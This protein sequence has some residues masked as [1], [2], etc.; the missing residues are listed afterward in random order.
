MPQI[1]E[2]QQRTDILPQ[3]PPGL[4]VNPNAFGAQYEATHRLAGVSADFAE[5]LIQKRAHAAAVDYAFSAAAQDQVDLQK[6]IQETQLNLPKN[7]DGS[8]NYDGY[9]DSINQWVQDRFSQNQKQAPTQLAKQ[10]YQEQAHGMLNRSIVDATGTEFRM[11]AENYKNTILTDL[12]RNGDSLVSVP[13]EGMAKDIW[14]M[15]DRRIDASV[16]TI[17]TPDEAKALKDHSHNVIARS[18]IDGLYA[19]GL[20]EPDTNKS[21]AW[22]QQGLDI[23]N[24]KTSTN[25]GMTINTSAD[26]ASGLKPHEKAQYIDRFERMMNQV[27]SVST[28]EL[29]KRLADSRNQAMNGQPF[30]TQVYRDLDQAVKGGQITPEDRVRLYDSQNAAF[31]TSEIAKEFYT[32]SPDQWKEITS[33]WDSRMAGVVSDFVSR[34]PS[35]KAAQELG[36]NS[37]ERDRARSMLDPIKIQ[38][39][40]DRSDD[41]A[42]Y[43]AKN[44]PG[45][46][47]KQKLAAGDPSAR[48]DYTTSLLAA[49]DSLKIPAQ[50]QRITTKS[51][52]AKLGSYLNTSNPEQAANA[53][54]YLQQQYGPYFSRAFNEAVDDKNIDPKYWAA[55]IVTDPIARQNI[56][57]NII[58][59]ENIDK[60]L[61][62]RPGTDTK[63]FHDELNQAVES[64]LGDTFQAVAGQSSQGGGLERANAMKDIVVMDAKKRMA[65]NKGLS[66]EDAVNQASQVIDNNWGH[67]NA[68]NSKITYP[69]VENGRP[70]SEP[71]LKA[72]MESHLNSDAFKEMKIA[73]PP[74]NYYPNLS[75]QEQKQRFFDDLEKYG[76]W[77]TN[78]SQDG[79]Y[80]ELHNPHTGFRMPVRDTNNGRVEY[81]YSDITQ[82]ADKRT[83]DAATP[84]L[85]KIMNFFTK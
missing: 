27:D 18:V 6:H 33:K 4:Q 80:L 62:G 41:P 59:G 45:I 12:Q 28:A 57:G 55:S 65:T 32:S 61:K 22:L 1:P 58:S 34:D 42:S 21:K 83:L 63:N 85:K 74:Q 69:R 23:M 72:F 35:L 79:L 73:P 68:A 70:I 5:Q 82:N 9:S 60:Q 77:V 36:F 76:H 67:I 81:R 37:V 56:M 30:S 25:R 50:F 17:N 40:K 48:Q 75:P 84:T 11:K 10:M 47:L 39:L 16:G 53:F 71:L 24:G 29:H 7:P 52:T 54:T 2:F 3:N 46:A 8:A 19:K 51:E 78:P 49:Q 38:I 64:K 31:T 44:F 20:G 43:V 13:N 66:M 15:Y 26:I 14:D